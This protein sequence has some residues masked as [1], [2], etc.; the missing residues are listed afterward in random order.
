MQCSLDP[1]LVQWSDR[2]VCLCRQRHGDEAG[3]TGIKFGR[4]LIYLED[5]A[6][7]ERLARAVGQAVDL[8]EAIFS[9]PRDAFAKAE[10]AARRRFERNG[11]VSSLC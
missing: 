9:P 5:C 2:N 3:R 1:F 7:L 8:R 11:N 4:L 6:A 10:I